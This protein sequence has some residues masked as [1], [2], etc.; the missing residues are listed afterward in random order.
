MFLGL[1]WMTFSGA[2]ARGSL[3]VCSCRLVLPGP[4]FTVS[5]KKKI[6]FYETH[7]TESVSYNLGGG[8][9]N[10]NVDRT[11]VCFQNNCCSNWTASVL[12]N[13]RAGSNGKKNKQTHVLRS[14][15]LNWTRIFIL[16][17]HLWKTTVK[18]RGCDSSSICIIQRVYALAG[19]F[20]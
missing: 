10:H 16:S 11:L 14:F 6:E 8:K 19:D 17:L 12:P 2:W 15:T 13:S 18:M 1:S 20:L 3:C 7:F 5:K 4:K 9:R